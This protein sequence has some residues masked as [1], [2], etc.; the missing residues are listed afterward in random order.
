MTENGDHLDEGG[1]VVN[2]R[3]GSSA[4]GDGPLERM[5]RWM[6][7]IFPMLILLSGFF[8]MVSRGFIPSLYHDIEKNISLD[9]LVIYAGIIEVRFLYYHHGL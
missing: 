4:N 1:P 5:L 7:R 3:R 8:I 2:K 9:S 6:L